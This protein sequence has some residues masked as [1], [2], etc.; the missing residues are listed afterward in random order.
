MDAVMLICA[1]LG[2]CQILYC[3]YK[4]CRSLCCTLSC[5]EEKVVEEPYNGNVQ[6]ASEIVN[7]TDLWVKQEKE[8]ET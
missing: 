1:G 3:I 8:P 4:S 2:C 5:C 7:I 6:N